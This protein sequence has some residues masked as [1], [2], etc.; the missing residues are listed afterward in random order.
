VAATR[1]QILSRGR[2]QIEDPSAKRFLI[3]LVPGFAGRRQL[4]YYRR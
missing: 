1:Q 2:S 3:V 4:E